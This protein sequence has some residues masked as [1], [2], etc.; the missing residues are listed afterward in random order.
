MK[1]FKVALVLALAA[2]KLSAQT[3]DARLDRISPPSITAS[4]GN[5]TLAVYGKLGT[6][7]CT[8]NA[9]YLGNTQLTTSYEDGTS[10]YATVAASLVHT[11]GTLAVQYHCGEHVSNIFPLTV[12]SPL[13]RVDRVVPAQF[14]AGLNATVTV[15]GQQFARNATVLFDWQ[16][17]STTFVDETKLTATIPGGLVGA[18]GTHKIYVYNGPFPG[19]SIT[20]VRPATFN[21]GTLSLTGPGGLPLGGYVI[22]DSLNTVTLGAPW[23]TITGADA[24]SF[25]MDAQNCSDGLILPP[26]TQ[27]SFGIL[28]TPTTA[29]TKTATLMIFS[30]ALNAPQVSTLTGTA[31][32][33]KTVA[34]D[35][36]AV[37]FGS[38]GQGTT[39]SPIFFNLFAAVGSFTLSTP[40]YMLGGANPGDFLVSGASTCSDGGA[41]PCS[42]GV[43]FSPTAA[44]TRT[45]TLAINSG[46]D[47][48]LVIPLAGVGGTATL[49]HVL[50]SW[51]AS[52]SANI[53]GYNIYRATLGGS[54]GAPLNGGTPVSAL[55]YTDTTPTPGTTYVYGVTAVGGPPSWATGVESAVVQSGPVTP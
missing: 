39:A 55:T 5:F 31:V 21:G 41:L 2:G 14:V 11:I 45:A 40:Y 38:T 54:F 29:G 48:L 34:A 35:A 8:A 9:I 37:T 4:Y 6:G 3:V 44:G 32:T 30:D 24:S 43:S 33:T 46:A 20:Y 17:L 53:V 25:T 16:A 49:H 47:N 13:A 22:R 12:V 18:S 27:C 42:T 26:S 36:G 50:L 15:Y 51:G 52:T 28:F 7:G 19:G 23:F 10:A 1:F